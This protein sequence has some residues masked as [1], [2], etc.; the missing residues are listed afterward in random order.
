[1]PSRVLT[2]GLISDTHGLLRPEAVEALK[3]SDFIIHAG[4]IGSPQVLADLSQLA[5]V[6]AIRGN[7]DRGA[8][9]YALPDNAVLQAGAAFIFVIHNL[10]DLGLDPAAAGF[11]AVVSGHSHQPGWR[12]KDGVL[13][14]NPGSAGPRRFKLPISVGRLLVTETGITADLIELAR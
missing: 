7:V 8:W 3:G 9:A 10:A 13:F 11:Q 14:V 2:I 5:P 4:D 1:M 12:E 6:T